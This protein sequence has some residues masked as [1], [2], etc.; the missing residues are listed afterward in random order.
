M[1]GAF[2]ISVLK[3]DIRIAFNHDLGRIL[4]RRSAGTATARE[5]DTGLF[6]SVL[7][8]P[9]DPSAMSVMAQ[10]QRRDVSGSS[11]SVHAVARRRNVEMPR[12]GGRSVADDPSGACSRTWPRRVPCLRSDER[13]GASG[14]ATERAQ[15]AAKCSRRFWCGHLDRAERSACRTSRA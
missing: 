3:D 6:Y 13:D 8:N 14:V 5:D 10:V 11:F 7:I 1:P 15:M 2:A 4:G 12:Y 9:L